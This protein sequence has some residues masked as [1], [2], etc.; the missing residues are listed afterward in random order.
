[1]RIGKKGTEVLGG[2]L[3]LL[4]A[5]VFG[6]SVAAGV[7]SCSGGSSSV[8][9]A[10]QPTQK[11]ATASGTDYATLGRGYSAYLKQ[12]GQCHGYML[13]DEDRKSVV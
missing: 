1:M 2:G 3:L 10:P 4:L 5:G 6:I 13:P 9:A 11:M 8:L 12:C 7:S